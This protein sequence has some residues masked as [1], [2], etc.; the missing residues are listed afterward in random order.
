MS[1]YIVVGLGRFGSEVALRLCDQ[2]CE[3]LAVDTNPELVQHVA[4]RVTHAVVAD[5]TD[6]AVLKALD[7][8]SFDCAIVA[9][10]DSLSNSVLVTMNLQE[11]GIP[12]LIC[13]ANDEPHRKVLL[14]MGAHQVV[15][16]EKEH[17]ARLARSLANPNVLDYIELSDACGIVEAPAP[18]KWRDKSL[19][20]LDIR[21]RLGLN[22]IA[23]KRD[24]EIN[25]FPSADY[26]FA[27]GDVIVVMGGP[28]TVEKLRSL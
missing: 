22:I 17:A 9:I 13:K 24:G 5:A 26:R 6:K 23:I 27:M 21:A 10:G 19:K 4:D 18:I 25:T 1:A 7:A 20:E 28:D 2:G 16:P 3:V 14:K 12:K 11:L 15:I 8:S